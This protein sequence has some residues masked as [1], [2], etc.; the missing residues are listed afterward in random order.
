M[1]HRGVE[2]ALDVLLEAA[3]RDDGVTLGVVWAE[4]E[5]RL[6][7]HMEGEEALLL[8]PFEAQHTEVA[9]RVRDEHATIRDR[10]EKMGVLV[11]LHL[12]RL[13]QLLEL[14]DL[15]RAHAERE[16]L[17]IYELAEQSNDSVPIRSFVQYLK[18]SLS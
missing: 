16:D 1:D 3:R 7:D 12:V 15:L 4:F 2:A 14:Q 6:R 5:R 9:Q 11:D 17:G 8:P 18:G 10:L 13:G